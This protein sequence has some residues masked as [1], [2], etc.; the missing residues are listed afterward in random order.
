MKVSTSSNEVDSISSSLVFVV[1][2]IHLNCFPFHHTGLNVRK[3]F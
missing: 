2:L 1:V 3:E